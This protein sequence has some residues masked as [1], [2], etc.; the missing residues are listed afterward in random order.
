MI[1]LMQKF[2]KELFCKHEVEYCTKQQPFFHLQ[3]GTVYK[4]C[5]K[6]GKILGEEFLTHEEQ[7]IRF[8]RYF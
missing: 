3:G 7:L 2:I 1:K 4:R 6:C 5:K 8:G